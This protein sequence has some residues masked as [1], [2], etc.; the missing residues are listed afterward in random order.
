MLAAMMRAWNGRRILPMTAS[1]VAAI[2]SAVA[3][4]AD[5]LRSARLAHET[6]RALRLL[7]VAALFASA[8]MM[9]ADSALALTPAQEKALKPGEIL[10]DCDHCPDMVALPA[11]RFM[12]GSRA[13]DPSVPA[14]ARRSE[15]PAHQ[16]TI[17]YPLAVGKFEVVG[18]EFRACIEEGGC[19]S[20]TSSTK[21]E[22]RQPMSGLTWHMAKDYATWL[23]RKTGKPYRLLTEA[24]WEYA[25]RAGTTTAYYTGDTITTRQARFSASPGK[26]TEKLDV[27]Q[28]PPN[29]FG[30]HDMAGNVEEWVEDCFN[31]GYQGAPTD[32][33]AWLT[34]TCD[35]RMAR[36]GDYYGVAAYVR[37]AARNGFSA[38]SRSFGFRVGRTLE[39]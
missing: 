14:A 27:G 31:D 33:S 22:G 25:A 21:P 12:M 2:T 5:N 1:A 4:H 15:E 26:G 13:D 35:I 23:A 18:D 38:S 19:K 6:H 20:W 16:V 9:S 28:F 37:S 8:A 36:G 30:L 32:G 29:P 3:P 17:A 10:K 39:K 7:F 11:G 34:G 24:E